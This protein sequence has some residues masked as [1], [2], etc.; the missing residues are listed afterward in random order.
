MGPTFAGANRVSPNSVTLRSRSS[1]G[2]SIRGRNVMRSNAARSP[3]IEAK[4]SAV[5]ARFACS[6]YSSVLTS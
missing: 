5:G 3:A 6:S 1:A 2:D 4:T